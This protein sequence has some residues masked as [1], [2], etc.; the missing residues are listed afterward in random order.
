VDELKPCGTYAA[1]RRHLR[2]SEAVDDACAEAARVQKNSRVDA[3][4]AESAAVVAIAVASEPAVE[5]VDELDEA[6]ENLRIVKA[7]MTA[8]PANAIAALSK[9]REE[10]V[11]RVSVLQKSNE[12][13]LSALDQLA[14]RRAD[15]IANSAS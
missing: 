4:R 11:R 12:P 13:E 15:R 14:Q 7:A 1:Y 8:A 2:N 6:L 3:G 9:R 5:S 10:L